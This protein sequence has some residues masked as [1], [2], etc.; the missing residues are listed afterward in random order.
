MD[1]PVPLEVTGAIQDF[2]SNMTKRKIELALKKG[3]QATINGGPS[4]QCVDCKNQFEVV[5]LH[6]VSLTRPFI[7]IA[8][9]VRLLFSFIV[10][11]ILWTTNRQFVKIGEKSEL[12]SQMALK[13]HDL[14]FSVYSAIYTERFLSEFLSLIRVFNFLSVIKTFLMALILD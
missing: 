10:T 6:S 3:Y 4:R 11:L 12:I 14:R 13:Q 8:N 5:P 2:V 7:L 9:F 1:G